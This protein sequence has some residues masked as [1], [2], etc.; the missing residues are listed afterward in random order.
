MPLAMA[1]GLFG[2]A[3]GAE[4]AVASP[5]EIRAR[6][7]AAAKRLDGGQRDEAVELLAEAITGL[8]VM[9]TAARLPVGFKTLADRAAGVR[10]RLDRAGADVSR[11]MI[12]VPASPAPVPA[13]AKPVVGKATGV[14]FSRQVAPILASSCGGCH[15]AGRK[16]GFQMMSYE[17]LMKT[18]MVQRGAGQASRLV[19]VILTGDMP[20][21]G[22]KVSAE[23]VATLIRWIDSGAACDAADP[24]V[25]IDVL[26]RGGGLPPAPA[27]PTAVRAVPLKPGGVSFASDVAPLLQTHC[28]K[29]HGGDEIEANLSMA[30]LDRLLRGGR[31]GAA[32]VPGKG[33]DSLLVKKLR[34]ADI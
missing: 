18:G 21:G 6:I 33:A 30:S 8:E 3:H 11:L 13:V 16:G 24:S 25:G 17:G 1:L 26:A 9:A 10:R 19:E 23:N 28:L 32:I 12:P 14:S 34:G 29:C 15:I 2:T 4:P 7:D 20:R 31:T 22:G 27:P 5:K